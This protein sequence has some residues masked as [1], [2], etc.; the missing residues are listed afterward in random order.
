MRPP[1]ERGPLRRATPA[2]SGLRD[3]TPQT[4]LSH[5]SGQGDGTG[6]AAVGT[7]LRRPEQH[8]VAPA[9]QSA[10]SG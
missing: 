4:G 9:C 2:D 1:G 10:L 3:C 8:I 5:R 6:G 7:K